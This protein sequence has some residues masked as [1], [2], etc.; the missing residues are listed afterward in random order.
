MLFIFNLVIFERNVF[1]KGKTCMIF[2]IQKASVLKRI[3]AFILDAIL[4][5]IVATGFAVLMSQITDYDGHSDRLEEYYASYEAEY[6]VTFRMTEEER[7]AMTKEEQEQYKKAYEALTAD[8][9]AMKEYAKVFNLTLTIISL[10]ILLSFAATEFVVPLC[11]KNGQTVGKKVFGI[12]VIRTDG[13][14]MNPLMLF[15]RTFLGKFTLETMIPVLIIVMICF[16]SIGLMGLI[17]LCAE[18][19]LQ[20]ILFFA[21]KTN[22]LIHDLLAGTVCVDMA[23]QMIFASESEMI[24]YKK[25]VSAEKA[26]RS[27]Y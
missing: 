16:N 3:S 11:L 5:C 27:Q 7:A 26:A 9:E 4:I 2:D 10:S 21:T 15:V 6:G 19:L 17:V 20:I 23:S 1:G 24:E 8:K 22:S 14:K 13:V 18:L 25:R 12:G